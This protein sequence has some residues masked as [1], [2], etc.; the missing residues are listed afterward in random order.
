MQLIAAH[1]SLERRLRGA[2]SWC[3]SRAPLQWRDVQSKTDNGVPTHHHTA[4]SAS[5][6]PREQQRE[7]EWVADWVAL[8]DVEHGPL[9]RAG[10]TGVHMDLT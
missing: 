6:T 7:V 8:V 1:L 5:H 4:A 2:E 3:A 10:I 9:P